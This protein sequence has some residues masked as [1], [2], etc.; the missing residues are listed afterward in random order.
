MP[1]CTPR[2]GNTNRSPETS[3]VPFSAHPK[4]AYIGFP[5]KRRLVLLGIVLFK[6]EQLVDRVYGLFH[7]VLHLGLRYMRVFGFS[8]ASGALSS[9]VNAFDGVVAERQ[10]DNALGFSCQPRIQRHL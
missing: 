6:P 10:C 2:E 9:S 7:D 8:G 5:T 1:P 4:I 3:Q